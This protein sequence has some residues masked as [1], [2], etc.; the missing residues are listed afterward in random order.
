MS[1]KIIVS[2]IQLAI[3]IKIEILYLQESQFI[4]S[5]ENTPYSQKKLACKGRS[6][7]KCGICR[8]WYWSPDGNDYKKYTKRDDATCTN[9]G[10]RD[11][12]GLANDGDSD[13]DGYWYYSSSFINNLFDTSYRNL[14]LLCECEN[15][16]K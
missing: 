10:W 2:L 12:D 3:Q 6:C 14:Y 4:A 13:L 5:N 15:N 9:L 8:D 7:A 11:G 1:L 16:H